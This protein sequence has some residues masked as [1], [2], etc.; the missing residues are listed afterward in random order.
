M[1]WQ[2]TLLLGGIVVVVILLFQKWNEFEERHKP[3]VDNHTVESVL[4]SA[5]PESQPDV[6][7]AADEIPT[8]ADIE[9]QPA[10]PVSA[11]AQLI[12]VK[13]DVLD[14][15]IDTNGGDIVRVALPQYLAHL[16]S[17]EPLILLNRTSS[18][19]YVAQSGLVGPDGTDKSGQRP[20]FVSDADEYRL[21]EGRDELIVDLRYQQGAVAITKRFV[22]HRG[23][24]LV[25]IHYLI[26]NGG[27]EDWKGNFYAQIKRDSSVPESDAGMGMQ[28]HVGP[29]LT[30]NEE[31]YKKFS[32]SDI[33]DSPVK[34]TVT[35]GWMAMLQH[36]FISAWVP[37]AGQEN[38]YRLRKLSG[39]DEYTFGFVAPATTVSSG[40]KGELTASFYAGPKDQKQL[41]KIAPYLDLT[42]DYGWAWWISKPLFALLTWMHQMVGNWGWAILLL[43]LCV[44]IP[45]YP[46]FAKSARSMAKMRKLQPEMT[47]LKELYGDDRQRMS[48]EMMA[49][50]KKHKANPMGGCLPMLIPLPIFIGLY[51]M[52]FE[53]V[54]LRHADWF[55]VADLS[56]KDPLFILP[57][58][59]GLSMWF[60]Q[61]L[62]P[63]P[64]DP[65][66]ATAMK[67]MPVIF[68]FMFMWF[69]AGLVLYWTVNNLFSIVQGWIVNKQMEKTG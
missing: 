24:Y 59:M 26:A 66:M 33:E 1:D 53:S 4:P 16:D 3:A 68:T 42:I 18:H 57:V 8:A 45:M 27:A 60:Q 47:R 19:T 2:R 20:T 62:N 64:A 25:A 48:Q 69:P 6:V 65:S 13:T 31:R 21:V 52:L 22:F 34:E 49:L 43:T 38:S 32:F 14:V 61:K 29:A 63:Q 5:V 56:V 35:G 12:S 54:E 41:E 51:Y 15:L 7:P 28:P 23:E 46:L 44:R 39:R 37:P 10:Q 40:E 36:Y 58:L 55:W 30:T 9:E 67:L 50:Y 11:S 17:N